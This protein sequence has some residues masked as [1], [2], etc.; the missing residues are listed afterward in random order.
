MNKDPKVIADPGSGWRMIKNPGRATSASMK[1]WV[2]KLLKLIRMALSKLDKYR[3]VVNFANSEG[4][5]EKGP[6]LIH[7]VAPLI[8][9]PITSKTMSDTTPI[10]YKGNDIV[11]QT[12][13]SVT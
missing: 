3:A 7:E 5:I 6:I 1:S 8:S 2:R 10:T 9:V 13:Q 11:F 4:C 12:C